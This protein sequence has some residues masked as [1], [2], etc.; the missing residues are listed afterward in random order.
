MP[1]RLKVYCKLKIK[2]RAGACSCRQ[3]STI[4]VAVDDSSTESLPQNEIYIIR[5]ILNIKRQKKEAVETTAPAYIQIHILKVLLVVR[6]SVV[7]AFEE[8]NQFHNKINNK[9][10]IIDITHDRSSL[11]VN[12]TQIHIL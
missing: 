5:M 8:R 11:S 7:T 2:C 3:V 10:Y 1:H 9:S 12:C 6:L 4:P